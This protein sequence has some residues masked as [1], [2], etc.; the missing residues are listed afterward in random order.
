M[1]TIERKTVTREEVQDE[2]DRLA[3]EELGIS[4]DDFLVRYCAGELDLN[5]P[6][7]LRVSVLARLLL[8]ENGHNGHHS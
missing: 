4:A 2:L 6:T 8:G 3:R 5:S 7:V 1:A